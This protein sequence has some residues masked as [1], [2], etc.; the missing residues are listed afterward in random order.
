MMLFKNVLKIL[1]KKFYL[2]TVVSEVRTK[3][4]AGKA[5]RKKKRFALKGRTPIPESKYA[6][7]LFYLLYHLRMIICFII[8]A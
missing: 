5:A 7:F 6:S 1:L 4:H 2:K 3:T 8:C